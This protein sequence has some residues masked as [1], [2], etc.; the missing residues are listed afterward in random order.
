MGAGGG[1]RGPWSSGRSGGVARERAFTDWLG[2]L[3]RQG[4][5]VLVGIG[6][7][8]AVLAAGDEPWVVACDPVVE[9]VHFDPGTAPRWIAHKA[10]H[11]NLSDLAAMGARPRYLVASLLLPAGTAVRTRNALSAGL[12]RAARE[13][14]CAVVGGDVAVTGGPLS[15]T[16]TALG[17]LPGRALTRD[18]ARVGD[19][20]HVTGPLGGSRAG[21]HL[22]F[23]ARIDAGL[24]LAQQAGVGAVMDVSDGLA[25]D[26]RTLCVASRVAGAV[27]DAARIPL[28]RDARRAA[29]G[30][31]GRTAL[32]HALG[33]GEDHELLFT[34]RRGVVLAWGE[35]V[36]GAGAE[37]PIGEIGDRAGLR[38]RDPSGVES[39]L[40]APLGFQHRV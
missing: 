8:A 33:D 29:A 13:A 3:H 25:I 15:V 12:E 40:G 23:R 36:L 2:R 16:I 14:G 19:T 22:R 18:A 28:H 27:L 34:V 10:V 4:P 37:V 32:E 9:G 1:R 26:L 31:S 20:I 39:S 30:G 21:R 6:D 5:G 38:L 17:S 35:A 7:D 11:R 24:W